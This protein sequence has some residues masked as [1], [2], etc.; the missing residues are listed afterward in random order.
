MGP[1]IA[2]PDAHAVMTIEG[3][4]MVR[5]N[6]NTLSYSKSQREIS[7]RVRL[8]QG[9]HILAEDIMK[10]IDGLQ[11]IARQ[12]TELVTFS[13][14]DQSS[15][16]TALLDSPEANSSC[17]VFIDESPPSNPD[18]AY[19]IAV[20]KGN[21]D[22]ETIDRFFRALANFEQALGG[23]RVQHIPLDLNSG[24]QG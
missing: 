15:G 18:P 22:Q 2:L 17:G 1:W 7:L 23:E 9:V 10:N 5:S 19:V 12:G 4:L 24:G 21:C 14:A 6:N 13:M 3:W 20:E 8:Q 11:M 16:S